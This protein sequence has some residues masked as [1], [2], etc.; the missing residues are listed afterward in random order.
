MF[1]NIRASRDISFFHP[2]LLQV[3]AYHFIVKCSSLPLHCVLYQWGKKAIKLSGDVT[4]SVIA[5]ACKELERG[6][7]TPNKGKLSP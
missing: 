1:A 2:E 3:K 4:C 5:G 7:G 6:K